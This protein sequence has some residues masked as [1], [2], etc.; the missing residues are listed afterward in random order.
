MNKLKILFLSLFLIFVILT[1]C[2][3]TGQDPA[4]N[5]L[6]DTKILSYSISTVAELDTSGNSTSNYNVMV[7][8]SGSDVDGSVLEYNYSVDGGTWVKETSAT[9]NIVMTFLNT[10]DTH[11]LRVAAID[12][13]GGVDQS[14]ATETIFRDDINIETTFID[15]PANGALVS[16]AVKYQIGAEVGEGHVASIDWWVD[17]GTAVSVIPNATNEASIIIANLNE[18]A[19]T[20]YFATKRDDGVSDYSPLTVSV[21]V[22]SGYTPEIGFT[23]PDD[24]ATFFVP[25]GQPQD[26]TVVT[27]E[28]SFLPYAG[29]LDHYEYRMNFETTWTNSGTEA[30][31]LILNLAAGS[32]TVYMRCYDIAGGM[33]EDSLGFNVADLY[34]DNGVLFVNGVDWATY[35]PALTDFWENAHA[36]G[37]VTQYKFWDA[38]TDNSTYPANLI[39][40][41]GKGFIPAFV[42]DTVYFKSIVWIGNSYNGDLAYWDDAYPALV[43][44]LNMGGNLLLASRQG[45]D[46]FSEPELTAYAGISGWSGLVTI[47]AASPLVALDANLEDVLPGNGYGSASRA[48]VC[49]LDGSVPEATPIFSYGSNV[50]GFRVAPTDG[51]GQFIFIAGRPYA[52]DGTAS[53]NNYDYILKTWFGEQ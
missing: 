26:T 48:N 34:N 39:P 22:Q 31:G 11:E 38:F 24:G 16:T 50:G 7:F 17:N 14:P 53:F 29:T 28:S 46:F 40:V 15:G 23:F 2:T 37:T 35:D 52:L 25:A 13:R 42:I 10:T 30:S 1:G 45:A 41:M 49:T 8:W 20:I 51:R 33:T 12:D 21:V 36:M 43:D 47:T 18:G 44:F 9:G 32:Y 4:A 3:K 27:W 5:K 6:P 19:H